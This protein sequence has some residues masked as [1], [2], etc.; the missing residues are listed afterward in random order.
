MKYV[1]EVL[2]DYRNHSGNTMK[3][4]QK[5]ID[6]TKQTYDY[7]NELI[8]TLDLSS[9]LPSVRELISNLLNNKPALKTKTIFELPYILK[10]WKVKTETTKRVFIRLLGMKIRIFK[11]KN[12]TSC[13]K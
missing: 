12:Q 10:V 2:L 3:D 11:K 8:K 9:V 7:E 5:I 6:M 4:N 13:E 1:D